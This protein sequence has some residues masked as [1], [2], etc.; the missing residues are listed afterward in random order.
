MRKETDI[1]SFAVLSQHLSG[2]KVE[3]HEKPQPA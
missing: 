3:N 1:V 2:G